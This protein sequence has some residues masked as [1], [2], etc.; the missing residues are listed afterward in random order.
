MLF[1]YGKTS[2]KGGV[3]TAVLEF[4]SKRACATCLTGINARQMIRKR[5]HRTLLLALRTVVVNRPSLHFRVILADQPVIISSS[6]QLV[7]LSESYP[8]LMDGINEMLWTLPCFVD[9]EL[10]A[11]R[12]AL[13]NEELFLPRALSSK[14]QPHT[15]DFLDI[16][17]RRP[18]LVRASPHPGVVCCLEV[19]GIQCSW[20]IQC[21]LHC[22]PNCD[23]TACAIEAPRLGIQ[24][25][26]RFC[27]TPR[28]YRSTRLAEQHSVTQRTHRTLPGPAGGN[29]VS[30][31]GYWTCAMHT[32]GVHV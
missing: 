6:V 22:I 5:K 29:R 4:V 30:D 15:S 14:I 23:L 19:G 28:W 32:L 17:T 24:W 13:I 27:F 11:H 1:P 25:P 9:A 10:A 16:S 2:G 3:L 26:H 12:R 31:F 18:K 21:S 7:C 20:G 8:Q